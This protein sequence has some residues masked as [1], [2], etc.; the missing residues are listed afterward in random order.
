MRKRE[1]RKW[2][3]PV[4]IVVAVSWKANDLRGWGFPPEAGLLEGQ[5]PANR[6]LTGFPAERKRKV[7]MTG[8]EQFSFPP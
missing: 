8:I 5:S 3:A 4:L 6:R 1:A 2:Y 7:G